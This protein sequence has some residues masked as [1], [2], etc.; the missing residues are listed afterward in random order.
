MDSSAIAAS[1]TEGGIKSK[2]AKENDSQKENKFKK[3][4]VSTNQD[5][6]TQKE[7]ALQV[8]FCLPQS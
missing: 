7:I 3:N 6:C 2:V 1:Q 8:I 5:G 4:I